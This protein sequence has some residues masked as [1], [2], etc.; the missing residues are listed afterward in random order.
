MSLGINQSKHDGSGQRRSFS[1]QGH[2]LWFEG[3]DKRNAYSHLECQPLYGSFDP[4]G[5]TPESELYDGRDI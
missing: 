3:G 2:S 1:H 5:D 4:M